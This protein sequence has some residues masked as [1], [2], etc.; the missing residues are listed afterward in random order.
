MYL[1]IEHSQSLL[2]ILAHAQLLLTSWQ[3]ISTALLL[4]K[5]FHPHGTIYLP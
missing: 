5:N 4:V 3:E 1:A 2:H